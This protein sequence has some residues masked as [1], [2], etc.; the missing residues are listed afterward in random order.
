MIATQP[1]PSDRDGFKEHIILRSDLSEIA[2]LPEWLDEITSHQPVVKQT[3]F[4]ID[5]C[6]EEVVTNIIRHGLAGESDRRISLS[7]K[8]P[9]QHLV[10]TIED[11]APPFNPLE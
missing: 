5:L 7:C 2:R 4:A 8:L 1:T 3:R 6:L 9:S 11:D 10:F